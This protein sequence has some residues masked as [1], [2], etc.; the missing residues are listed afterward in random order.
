[1]KRNRFIL[2]LFLCGLNACRRH[3][4]EP[5]SSNAYPRQVGDIAFDPK[6]D[7]PNFKVCNES[8]A[9]QYYN[10]DKGL[11][12]KGEKP[13]IVAHFNNGFKPSQKS[14]ET[15]FVTIRFIVNCEGK[16]GWFR[17]LGIDHDYKPKKFSAG[18]VNQLL[19]LTKQLNGWIVGEY[20]GKTFDYYQYLTFKMEN[21]RLIEIMP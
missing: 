20:N 14:T 2:L 13:A 6:V 10:F 21:G 9:Q 12:Y 18:L 15:G 5:S 3:S 17:V 11:L 1:M 16:T 7:D 19:T 8:R 4:V